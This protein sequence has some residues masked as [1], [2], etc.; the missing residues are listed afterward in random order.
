MERCWTE[1][2]STP[3]SFNTDLLIA[4]PDK[5]L[6]EALECLNAGI[7]PVGF[8]LFAKTSVMSIDGL[9]WSQLH[10]WADE[11]SLLNKRESDLLRAAARIPRFVPSAKDCEKILKIKKNLEAKGFE[12]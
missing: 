4:R 10:Q 2:Q 12:F 1:I 3:I 6:N 5:V 8:G 9:K 11:R 7:Q